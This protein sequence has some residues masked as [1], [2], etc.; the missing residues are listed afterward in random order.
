[1]YGRFSAFFAALTVVFAGLAAAQETTGT[2]SGRIIDPQRL[3]IP[4]VT[5]T[6]AGPQGSRSVVTDGEGRFSVPFLTPGQ[7]IL[8]A[9]LQ[10][11]RT[12]EQRNIN[13]SLGQTV[14]LNLEMQVGG[15]TETVEVQGAAPIID[16]QSTTT[17]AVLDSDLFE[18]VPI[19]RRVT[20]TLYLAPG[21][22]ATGVG[23]ANPS[24]A[25]SS[26]LDNQYV[27]DGVN[28]TNPGYGAIGA[29]SIIFGSLGQATPFDFVQEVQVKTGGYQAEFGQSM[30]GIVNVITKS[31]TNDLRGSAFA[32]WQ[33]SALQGDWRQF[34]SANGSVNTVATQVQDAGVE[35][36]FPIIRDRL[37]GFVAINPAW[38]T[39]TFIAPEG[40]PL[41]SLSEVDRDRRTVSYSA[42]LTWQASDT[43]RVD[44]SFFGDPSQ[45]ENGP[46]RDGAL[47]AQD[48][49]QFSAL[50][51]GGHN[52]TARY[53]G[54]FG[55]DWLVEL[56]IARA[57]TNLEE[58]P[59]VNAW[60][61]RDFRVTPNIISGGI[62]FF[63]QNDGD[64][65]QYEAKSTHLFGGHQVRYGLLFEDVSWNQGSNRTGPTFTAPDGRQT[66]T[67]AQVQIRPDPVFGQIFR[68]SRANFNVTRPTE[69]NYFAAFLQDS[70]R[71]TDRLTLNAG[72][73]YEQQTLFGTIR[74]LVMFDPN[75]LP[76]GFLGD[77]A[78]N[79]SLKNNWAPRIGV[80]YDVL[81]GGMSRLY[82]N[83]GR[84]YGRV[85][86]DLAARALSADEGIS[87]ADFF[88][89]ALTR[90]VPEGVLA[91]GVTQ[92]FVL[93]G[94]HPSQ[95]DPNAKLSFKDE[96]VGGF[97]WEALPNTTLGARYIYRTVGRALEDVALFPL[98]AYDLG[99]PDAASVEY[100]MTNPD[101][102]FPT[103]APELGARHEDPIHHYNA[104]EL[105]AN[106]RFAE[107][108]MLNAS[109]RFSRLRGT[110]EGFF[111]EDNG[112]SDPGLTSLYDFPTNDPSYTAIGVPQFGYQGDVRF[113]GE[114]GEG[115]LPLDRP[116]DLKV[117]GNYTFDMGLNLGLRF[118]VT[119]GRPLT[120]L[121]ANPAYTNG[122]E[123]PL[124]PRGAGFETIDGFR[125]RTP[126]EHQMDLQ[127]SYGFDVADAR[128]VTLFADV[129]N[130][131]N[132][133]RTLD[134]D[135][136]T[137]LSLGVPNPDFG[138]PVSQNFSG[139]P[140]FQR[141]FGM[142]LGARF[143]F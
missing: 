55:N 3:A 62:G 32:Y 42:K 82:A 73:R 8:R 34:Q 139:A 6:I 16:T 74:E 89:A 137:E 59:S 28:I 126:V 118:N 143:E 68:V 78:D 92:H 142:R 14:D 99:H 41:A 76:P 98:V 140:Q 138:K 64:N 121:A 26:G 33:P 20:D 109:Y 106:R 67:G 66:A 24:F 128:R 57:A 116:H 65:L 77:S 79:F 135:N 7:Y 44:A 87:R 115:P 83:Y 104:I 108:W 51:Y 102:D 43:H 10:G 39:R 130:V 95:I 9:E 35:G 50:E 97:E 86:N 84:F 15:L 21:V 36:G 101:P 2:L 103:L 45:G 90:P 132:Q 88:D 127:A 71:A 112:Q 136:W 1:M 13:V 12:I 19:G 54:V 30:G 47:R 122:G 17:G 113:L 4:G 37:F 72:V 25:G 107:N 131:F 11:F 96:F 38:D 85:P 133:T 31:G 129:F 48:T 60:N 18:R 75:A 46:Q 124:T 141:P 94:V 119:S 49:S 61:V 120:A 63:E 22:T 27:V 100:I 23:T 29:Y 52:Q 93:A 70:W 40:S 114:L 56:S 80:V 91:A 53:D 110:Y 111:R 117:S 5:V 69:Q 123:I 58:I 105:T 81:G 134:Y 125:T